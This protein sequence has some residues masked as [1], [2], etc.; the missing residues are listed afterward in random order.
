MGRQALGS[1]LLLCTPLL[2]ADAKWIGSKACAQC[3]A[4]IFRS[5]SATPM[6]LSSGVAGASP[7]PEKLNRA[8][9]QGNSGYLYSVT[10]RNHRLFLE[11]RKAGAARL[12]TREMPYYVGSGAAARSY[13]IAVDGF[14]Y[15]AP[16]TYYARGGMWSFSPGYD[17]YTYPFLTRAIAPD[18]LECHAT[19]VNAIAGTQN[20]FASP[21][22]LEGGVGCERCHGPGARHAASGKPADIV[23]PAT[24]AAE[25]RESV[26]AQC[27]LSGTIRVMRAGKAM[28]QF[29]AGERLSD[30]AIAFVPE[31]AAPGMRVTSHVENLAQSAC[32]RKSEGKRWCGTC[33]DPHVTP[34]VAEKAAWF[35]SKC[36]NCHAPAVCARGPNCIGCHMPKS[37]VS[38][39]DHVVYTDHSIPRLPAPRNV[40][41]PADVKLAAFG[42]APASPRDLGLAYAIVALREQNAAYRE[43]AFDLL[44][45]ANPAILTIRKRWLTWPIYIRRGRTM[46]PPHRFTRNCAPPTLRNRAH[47]P[48]SA[49]IRWS[50]DATTRRS[51]SSVRR[52]E[53]VPRS[54][55]C[56]L[57]WRWRCFARDNAPKRAP[58]WKKLSSSILP[59]TPRAICFDKSLNNSWAIPVRDY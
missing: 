31:T 1:L 24:L 10:T 59:S 39:A 2:A 38:D 43:R 5:Y 30:Y 11:F 28:S 16:A 18:C 3:H 52:C 32:S 56:G 33:H 4:N 7:A 50:K 34:A 36:Q 49:H 55:W 8:S 9:F 12:E 35:R 45:E 54:C 51:S 21:P 25:Q 14:L 15:E 20:G 17:R 29:A 19:G 57:T 27:H 48:I 13:L 41:P 6:A 44:R 47:P 37:S 26:C 53:S 23:N 42:G 22:F 40:K 46:A 58:F